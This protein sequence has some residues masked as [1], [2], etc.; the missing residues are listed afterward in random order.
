MVKPS[1]V[2][3][4]GLVLAA[5]ILGAFAA[6]LGLMFVPPASGAMLLIPVGATNAIGF[7]RDHGATLLRPGALPGSVVVL[8][9]RDRLAS[10]PLKIVAVAASPG[11]CGARELDS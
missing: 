8:G 11:G 7:A 1:S 5:Q 3:F 9:Q 2:S 10:D 4:G 6:P